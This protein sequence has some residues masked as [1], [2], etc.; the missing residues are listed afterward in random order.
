MNMLKS[1]ML[2]YLF[3]LFLVKNLPKISNHKELEWSAQVMC[4]RA[5]P[6]NGY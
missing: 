6:A 2:I 3:I 4:A 1:R 5:L